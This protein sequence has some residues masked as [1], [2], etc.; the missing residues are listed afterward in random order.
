MIVASA[1]LCY[2]ALA[3]AP[4]PA[5]T[6]ISR[7]TEIQVYDFERKDDQ[8]LDR[9][10]DDWTRRRGDGFPL[11][12]KA[13]IDRGIGHDSDHSLKFEANGGAAVYYSPPIRVDP[14]HAL[15]LEGY[16]RSD[17][18]ADT[19]GMVSV[20]LLDNKRQRVSRRLSPAV[21]GSRGQ[22]VR[23]QVGPLLPGPEVRHAIIGCHLLP[24][25]RV[26]ISGTVHFDDLRLARLPRLSLEQDQLSH[27]HPEDKP[28]KLLARLSGLDARDQYL[29]QFELSDPFGGSSQFKEFPLTVSVETAAMQQTLV[30]DLP[31]QQPG[32]YRVQATLQRNGEPLITRET[33]LAV[34]Q[35]QETPPASGGF[36]WSLGRHADIATWEALPDLA[37]QSG[38]NWVKLPVWSSSGSVDPDRA[39][40]VNRVFE[41]LTARGIITVGALDEPPAVLLARLGLADAR[42]SE[43]F[44]LTSEI[45]GPALHPVVARY[46]ASVRYWQIGDD[47]DTTLSGVPDLQSVLKQLHREITSVGRSS[48]LVLPWEQAAPPPLRQSQ[49]LTTISLTSRGGANIRDIQ[50]SIEASRAAGYSSW[51]TL[52]PDHLP[53]ETPPDRAAFLVRAMLAARIGGAEAV[54]AGDV[55]HPTRGLLTADGAPTELYLPWRTAALAMQGAEYVGEFVFPGESHS[56]VFVRDN[57]A[58]LFVWGDEPAAERLFLGGQPY[59]VDVWGRR[60]PLAWD[61]VSQESVIPV[62]RAPRLIRGA[63]AELAR[64]R[65]AA[66]FASGRMKSE[67]GWH[68][69]HIVGKNSFA[70]GVSGSLVVRLPT[71]WSAEPGEWPLQLPAG[72][73]YRLPV[74]LM[75]P[76]TARMGEVRMVLEFDITADQ[77]YRFKVHRKYQ[78]GLGDVT[79]DVIDRRLPDGRLEIEQL[80]RNQT[81]PAE[82]LDFRCSL[83]VPGLRRQRFTITRLGPGQDRKL[84]HLPEADKL[85]GK[86]LWLRLE[87]EGGRRILN[88]RWTVG[89][90]W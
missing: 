72:E 70:Q 84:Y 77:N 2:L 82:T 27:F 35:F 22:W 89:K 44:T 69:D 56:A 62:D 11:Y 5:A 14:R 41:R 58:I 46:G 4:P 12:V 47:D 75:L 31:A 37:V 51:V 81:S 1:T 55:L 21:V 80:V 18:L 17:R 66:Q 42:A 67:Y 71:D 61:D 25:E 65:V 23:V 26:E 15:L 38:I 78:V 6:E 87:Q 64:W 52:W 79:I 39:G 57:E 8:D 9:Q 90:D 76:T 86:E 50:P 19:A 88:Y 7:A 34:M 20:S 53:G 83:F 68:A 29:L 59:E 85:R 28:L 40:R 54:F 32:F 60:K 63:S 10:P 36:G 16:I 49:S 24:G 43:V 3:W 73:P 48:R 30:W 33:T 13:E 45:W 74:N